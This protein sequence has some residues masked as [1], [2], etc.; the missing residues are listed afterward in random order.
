MIAQP[1]SSTTTTA[2][3]PESA[4]ATSLVDNSPLSASELYQLTLYKWRYSLEAYGFDTDEVREL[5]FLKWLHASRR[6]QP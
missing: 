1:N 5:M 2:N 6:I 4:S 3:E